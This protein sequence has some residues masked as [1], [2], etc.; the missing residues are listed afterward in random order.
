VKDPFVETMPQEK[1]TQEL[2]TKMDAIS[3]HTDTT[4]TNS[5]AR[6]QDSPLIPQSH[7]LL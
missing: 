6:D 1:D 7:S 5:L 4:T 3:T 2:V